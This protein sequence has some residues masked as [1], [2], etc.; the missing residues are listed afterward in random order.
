M[1]DWI[2][3]SVF[4]IFGALL[5]PFLR[6]RVQRIYIVLLPA[7][8]L[9]TVM[10]MSPGVHGV[11]H[12]LGF[13]LIFGRVD[14]LSLAFAYVF[15]CA[16][17][18]G[19]TYALHVKDNG[20]HIAAFV[21]AGS[22]LGATFAGDLLTLFVFWELMAFASV[23]LI[24]SRRVQAS[25][26]AGYRYLLVHAVGGVVLLAGIVILYVTTKSTRFDVMQGQ[27]PAFYL[28]LIGFMLNAAV[29]PLHAWLTD[30]YPEATVTG[31]VF[32]SA[33]TTKTAVYA[34]IRA[35]PGTELLIWMGTFMALYGVVFAML[36]NDIRRLLGYHIISQVG[37][38]VAAVGMGTALAINGAVAHAFAHILYKGLLFMGAG[39]IIQMTG[40]SKLSELGGLYRWMPVTFVLYMIGAFSISAFPLF[41]GFVSKSMEISAAGEM[42]LPWIWL[43]LT[44]ASVGTFLCLGL[45]I[46]YYAFIGKDCGARP[47]E[48]PRNMLVAMGIAAFLCIFI[49][50]YPA[51]LY[52][53]LP[54]PV[55]YHPYTPTHVIWALQILL[56]T[57]M[58]FFMLRKKLGGARKITLDIDWFYRKGAGLFMQ[59]V[60]RVVVPIENWFIQVYRYV[61]RGNLALG[62]KGLWLDKN[63]IDGAVNAI[64][65]VVV[66]GAGALRQVQTGQLQ[67]YA[68]VMVGSLLILSLYSLF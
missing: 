37:F 65:A 22:S 16:A 38:M 24:W 17:L 67:Q 13:E 32:L 57:G 59:F 29:P 2:H 9:L 27:G 53:K 30:A 50:V 10:L 19:A 8:A 12:F 68:L 18:I 20:Q 41:S 46:P 52:D 44:L 63:V 28:I 31:A 51:W 43:L 21:Y 6:G 42:H 35:Y 4:L 49:G 3:P 66:R 55:D 14:K 45:K 58:G 26:E 56:F 7:L 34:L 47:A 23:W 54:N 25:I 39:A 1:I 64:A 11:V 60:Y 62:I 61:F 33:F 40:Q 48:P 15:S 5:I 36:S